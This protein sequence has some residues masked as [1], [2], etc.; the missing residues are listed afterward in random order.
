VVQFRGQRK[1]L[2][3]S[4]G[5]SFLDPHRAQSPQVINDLVD[6]VTGG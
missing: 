1:A 5:D 4:R 2:G 6:Q 3:L